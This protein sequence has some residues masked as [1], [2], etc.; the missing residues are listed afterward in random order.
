ML[1]R[2]PRNRLLL[3]AGAVGAAIVVAVVLILVGSGGT[4]HAATTTTATATVPAKT[5][6]N[7]SIFANVPQHGDTLGRPNAPVTLSVFEDPQCP[8]CRQ[9]DLETLPTVIE[10]YVKTGRV[11]LVY[12]GIEI[13]G[14]NSVLG[15]QAIYAAGLENKLWTFSDEL[16]KLQGAENS[17]WIT[18]AVIRRAARATGAD[19]T[20]ILGALGSSGVRAGLADAKKEATAGAV[21]GTPTFVI[22]RPPALPQQLSVAALDPATFTQALDAAIG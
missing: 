19:G 2:M 10:R 11:K 5:T 20:A 18:S 9:W 16:Y 6:P 4:K 17:G 8:F 15:L 21:Q 7:A 3:L 12:R 22:D 14:P 13:I 1:R